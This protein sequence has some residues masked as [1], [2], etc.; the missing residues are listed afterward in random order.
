[1]LYHLFALVC[2]CI[3]SLTVYADGFR[4]AMS[5]PLRDKDK[6][7]RPVNETVVRLTNAKIALVNY[8]LIR[9]D[10]PQTMQWSNDQIDQWLI[11]EFAFISQKQAEQTIVNTPIPVSHE[12]RA[13]YRP[14]DY[15]RALVYDARINDEFVGLMDVKGAGSVN[16]SMRSHGNGL[17][18]LGEALREYL[19]ENLIKRILLAEDLDQKV[20]GT[21]AVIYAGMDVKHADGKTDPAGLILRQAHDRFSGTRGFYQG[22]AGVKTM[23]KHRFLKHGIYIGDNLQATPG[24]AIFDFGH[25]VTMRMKDLDLNSIYI[26]LKIFKPQGFLPELWSYPESI[27]ST[28][29]DYSKRDYPWMRSHDLAKSF[30]Q[31]HANR[32]DIWNL[33]LDFLIPAERYLDNKWEG[34]L[35]S[36]THLYLIDRLKHFF[37]IRDENLNNEEDIKRFLS[38]LDAHQMA[39][40][41]HDLI[42]WIAQ[43]FQVDSV[44]HRGVRTLFFMN[45]LQK[46]LTHVISDFDKEKRQE[47]L[48]YLKQRHSDSFDVLFYFLI[49]NNSSLTWDDEII[50]IAGQSTTLQN[51]MERYFVSIKD[52]SCSGVLAKIIP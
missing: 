24:G 29:F 45:S 32:D 31:G 49:Q 30:V 46:T 4:G 21:Y 27:D 37:G 43:R 48:L 51:L 50:E 47:I 33:Y 10:F 1:M 13:A 7:E 23:I 34:Q 42:L 26:D 52:N 40:F 35:V 22:S 12:T 16:P 5:P 18:T 39:E 2:C 17:A 41:Y 19:Y 20:V 8:P 11:D 15:G 28:H 25:Y 3:I 44:L 36:A 14:S 6:L 38:N 9:H